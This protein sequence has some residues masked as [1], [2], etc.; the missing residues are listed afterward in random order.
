MTFLC[1]KIDL[2]DDP[3]VR[4]QSGREGRPNMATPQTEKRPRNPNVAQSDRVQSDRA[5]S[6][7]GIAWILTLKD[8]A[9]IA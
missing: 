3:T 5:Y 7:L 2:I 4:A 1:V 6:D 8:Q 9:G